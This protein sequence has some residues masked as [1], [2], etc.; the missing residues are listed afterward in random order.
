MSKA[1]AHM[2]DLGPALGERMHMAC[3]FAALERFRAQRRGAGTRSRVWDLPESTIWTMAVWHIIN[4]LGAAELLER[5]DAEFAKI[6]YRSPERAVHTW[7]QRL[8]EYY[9]EDLQRVTRKY[10]DGLADIPADGNATNKHLRLMASAQA[11]VITAIESLESINDLEPRNLN[12]LAGFVDAINRGIATCAGVPLTEAK[13]RE[14][15]ARLKGELDSAND[16]GT[17]MSEEE[18]AKRVHELFVGDGGGGDAER[19][20]SEEA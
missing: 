3:L 2:P 6:N 8:G 1:V 19:E 9:R 18:I 15:A 14:I 13:A 17:P 16:R 4:G 11:K 7:L 20:G 10:I 12:A 5:L